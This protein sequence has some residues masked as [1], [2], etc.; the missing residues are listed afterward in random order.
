MEVMADF[1][2]EWIDSGREPRQKP[3]SKALLTCARWLS[4]CLSI[5]WSKDDIPR[6]E[7]IW[8]QWHDDYGRLL[9]DPR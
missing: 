1:K 9:R 8:W 7:E 6:L 4:Y 5:G 3:T 2:I